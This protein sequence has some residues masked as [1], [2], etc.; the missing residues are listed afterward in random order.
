MR[1][2]PEDKSCLEE[3][4]LHYAVPTDQLKRN[5]IVLG[6]ITA[7]FNRLTGRDDEAAELLRYMINRRKNADWPRLEN[8]AKRFS[9][10]MKELLDGEVHV[11]VGAYVGIDVPLDEY[12]LR[13]D[14]GARL[15][16]GFT[17]A[18]KRTLPTSILVAALMAYRKRG[19]LPCL[20]EVKTAG[21]SK[22]FADI[23][24]VAKMTRQQS[25]G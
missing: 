5:S 22:P 12:L 17:R 7:A 15:A 18:T 4:Y 13:D 14:L 8:R 24:V 20:V 11:L 16:E 3:L 19:F 6:R 9:S 10:A 25:A 23:K 1:L 21:A 2:K